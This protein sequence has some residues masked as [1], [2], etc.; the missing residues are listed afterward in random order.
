[1]TDRLHCS[2]RYMSTLASQRKA[3]IIPSAVL[4]IKAEYRDILLPT[5][6]VSSRP[7]KRLK[8]QILFYVSLQSACTETLHIKLP[9]QVN[10]LLQT[11]PAYRHCTTSAHPRDAPAQSNPAYITSGRP[12]T[13]TSAPLLGIKLSAQSVRTFT[14][15]RVNDNIL[16][17]VMSH[18]EQVHFDLNSKINR[19]LWEGT[20]WHILKISLR[21][22]SAS[23]PKFQ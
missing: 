17:N 1:M 21:K 22:C 7:A 13:H 12:T 23:R 2:S 11:R 3:D 15:L 8:Q 6:P 14:P 20:F 4:P 16:C 19:N 5:K 9:E 18:S 10:A